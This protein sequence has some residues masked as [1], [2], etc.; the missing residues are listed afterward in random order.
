MF[1]LL[2]GCTTTKYIPVESF[3]TDSVYITK[4][5]HDTLRTLDSVYI[6]EK[7]D[8]VFYERWRTQYRSVLR[9]DTMLVTER[10][11]IRV[12]YEVTVEKSVPSYTGA[13]LIGLMLLVTVMTMGFRK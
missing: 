10:D 1:L 7:G 5:T 13:I 6:H 3:H 4:H 11:T 8:T 2:T 12:P 9:T